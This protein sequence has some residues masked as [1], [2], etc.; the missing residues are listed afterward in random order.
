[1]LKQLE[2]IDLI[3]MTKKITTLIFMLM[4]NFIFS[5]FALAGGS[6]KIRVLVAD[7]PITDFHIRQRVN[8][9]LMSSREMND[10]LRA[11]FKSKATQNQW[12]AYVKKKQP[13]SKEEALKLQKQFAARLRNQVR[14][15]FAAR[16]KKKVLDEL[17]EER[18]M[19]ATAKS[20]DIIISDAV[21]NQS[22]LALAKRSS[23][24]KS[25]AQATKSFFAQ[26]ASQGVGR[27]TFKDKIRASLAWRQLI[28][29]KFGREVNFGDR[30]VE[31][32]LGLDI[33]EKRD[34]KVQFNLQRIVIDIAN[35]KDQS[36]V[37]KQYVEADAIRQRFRGC[38]NMKS[39]LAPYKSAKAIN[40]GRK[41]LDEIPSPM[42]LI[43]SDMK[44]GQ[45]TP[46]QATSDGLE[47]YAVCERKQVMI[48]AKQK[49]KTISKMRQKAFNLRAKRYLKDIRDEAHI[50]YRD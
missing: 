12:R 8:L 18:L 26:L 49:S 9:N 13:K 46:P 16:L 41:T 19:I 5:S 11:R 38:A 3:Y 44:A 1:M 4:I 40:L 27:S 20:E 14:S 23:K 43:L 31:Q 47:M 39:L 50:E 25:D 17:I 2:L 35:H 36:K 21:L 28:R 33:S 48:D 10:R 22:I 29:R 32:E 37:V 34:K 6:H 30:D 15:G 7:S 42:N 45:I 24:S